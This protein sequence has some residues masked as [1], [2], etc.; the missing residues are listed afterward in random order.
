M[1]RFA[2]V[3]GAFHGAWCWEPR[4]EG[5]GPHGHCDRPSGFRRRRDSDP[6]VTLDAYAKRVCDELRTHDK[7]AVVVAHS[8]GGIAIT[9]R[10]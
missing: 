10:P 7:P 4:A 6:E 3:H 2:L 5:C 9:Q 8:M 1:A